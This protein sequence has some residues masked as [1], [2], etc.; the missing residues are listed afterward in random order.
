MGAAPLAAQVVVERIVRRITSILPIDG[1]VDL[2]D[3]L[4]TLVMWVGAQEAPAFL[5]GVFGT[6]QPQDDAA[7]P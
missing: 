5:E 7:R 3:G 2:L 1:L 4:D 6:A